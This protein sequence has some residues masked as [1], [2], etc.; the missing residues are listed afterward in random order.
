MRK[1]AIVRVFWFDQNDNEGYLLGSKPV[2]EEGDWR[3]VSD[4]EREEIF[5]FIRQTKKNNYDH[6]AYVVIEKD[7]GSF[8]SDFEKWKLD[9]IDQ[10]EKRLKREASRAKLESQREEKKKNRAIEKA[11]KL[12]KEAGIPV[13]GK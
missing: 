8:Y 11:K 13:S 3:E 1:I 10:E 6:P 7:T 2:L 4:K 9:K 5:E 12:L